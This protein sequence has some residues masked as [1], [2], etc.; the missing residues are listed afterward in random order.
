MEIAIDE[1]HKKLVIA[2]AEAVFGEDLE[3]DRVIVLRAYPPRYELVLV[4]N[5]DPIT[6]APPSMH[7]P[8]SI[9]IETENITLHPAAMARFLGGGYF[10]IG[11][12]P[13]SKTI[14]VQ[15]DMI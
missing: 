2:A 8:D 13:Q 5:N 12:G 14:V 3:V 4:V 11:Y 7:L 9:R 1:R 15:G 6:L 10:R